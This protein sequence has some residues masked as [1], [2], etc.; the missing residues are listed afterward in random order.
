MKSYSV[1]IS[2]VGSFVPEKVLTNFDLSQIVDTNNEWIVERTGI[3]ERRIAAKDIATSDL[4]T[5][6]ALNA[7]KDS[8]TRPEEIDL[9]IVATATPDH[10]FPSTACIVQKNIGATKAAAFDMSVGCTGFVYA[11]ITGA[12]FIQTGAYEKVLIIGAETL[13]K[14]VDWV[15]RNTCV[16]FGDGAGSCVLERCEDGYGI[17]SYELG[18][19]GNNGDALIL[20]AGGSRMP[21]SIETVTD[22]LHSI[23]MDGKEVFKF[24]VRVME[25]ASLNVLENVH[26]KLEDLDFLIPHQANVRIIDAARKKLN[27]D[28]NKVCI[29]LNKYGNMSSAS[30]PVSL[31]EVIKKN[32]IKK[33]DLIVMVAFGA[34]L[35]WGSIAI[36]WNREE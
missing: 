31:D 8:K 21:A 24:A 2:G 9:I 36:K 17:L 19:D 25:K 30:I 6:S 34:G 3:E 12:N 35:T 10:S 28:E 18:S 5:E 23:K 13:S 27:I 29:N 33:G 7:L 15:D 14:I 20:P 4:A 26:L 16:L 32:R 11:L 22:R 1:G